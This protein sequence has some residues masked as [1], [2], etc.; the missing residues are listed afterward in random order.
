MRSSRSISPPPLVRGD[1]SSTLAP[2]V[3][4][5]DGA[6]AYGLSKRRG[7]RCEGL[8]SA[9]IFRTSIVGR[10]HGPQRGLLEWFLS[11]RTDAKGFED[12]RWNGITALAWAKL[13]L[14]AL[15]VPAS[16]AP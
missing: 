16:L 3:C 10:E 12:Q 6:D 4:S 2:T 1:G 9:V 11:E 13:A 15:E 5:T 7:E 8:T 14:Q